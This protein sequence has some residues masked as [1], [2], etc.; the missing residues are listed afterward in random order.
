MMPKLTYKDS[1]LTIIRKLDE[2]M[3]ATEFM[4]HCVEMATNV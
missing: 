3:T 2:D 4:Q 1:G